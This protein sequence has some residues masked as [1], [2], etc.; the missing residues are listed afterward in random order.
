MTIPIGE[1][2][3]QLVARTVSFEDDASAAP[4]ITDYDV[5]TRRVR[6]VVLHTT[7]GTCRSGAV[8]DS[9]TG[10]DAKAKLLAKY[11]TK[12]DRHVSWDYTVGRDGVIYAQ[13]NPAKLYSWHATSWNPISVGIELVQDD[14]GALY[15]GQLVSLIELVDVLTRELRIQ[16]QLAVVGGQPVLSKLARADEKGALRG[17]D[18]VGIFAHCHNTDS[19]GPGDPGPAPFRALLTAGYEGF[20]FAAGAD[21]EAWRA[22]Q[23]ISG[24]VGKGVDGI[25][26]D[27]TCAALEQAGRPCGLWVPRPGDAP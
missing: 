9:F 5:R 22:R 27:T 14:D 19:R 15:H 25:A 13:N 20:D 4:Q 12:T 1:K 21:R 26:L 2:R 3:L 24:I 16:R 7:S 17:G 8:K 18:M 10:S 6:A 11:Q 23:S